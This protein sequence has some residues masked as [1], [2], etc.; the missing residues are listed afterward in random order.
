MGLL[1]DALLSRPATTRTPPSPLPASPSLHRLHSLGDSLSYF[2]VSVSFFVPITHWF[3]WS[4]TQPRLT[5]DSLGGKGKERKKKQGG[6]GV[7]RRREEI[8]LRQVKVW[9]SFSPLVFLPL[10]PSPASLCYVICL[11]PLS[12]EPPPCPPLPP[13]APAVTHYLY[14]FLSNKRIDQCHSQCFCCLGSISLMQRAPLGCLP[15]GVG[16]GFGGGGL[17]RPSSH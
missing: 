4:P 3:F 15:G 16:W 6:T 13:V 10:P 12:S 7:S 11:L 8:S 5:L 1:Q 14:C 2:S 9:N 17:T